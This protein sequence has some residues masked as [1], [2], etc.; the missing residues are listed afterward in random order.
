M[1]NQGVPPEVSATIDRYMDAVDRVNAAT[2]T[3]LRG[4]VEA[5]LGYDTN[6]NAATSKSSVALPGYGG[7]IILDSD[8]RAIDAWFGT[9]GGRSVSAFLLNRSSYPGL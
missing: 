9:V 5:S 7:T 2:R 3:T 4:F 8:S 6:V 1:Q